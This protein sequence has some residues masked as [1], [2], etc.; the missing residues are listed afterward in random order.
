MSSM[1]MMFEAALIPG[2]IMIWPVWRI[3]RRTGL[4]PGWA[5]L[6][7]LP[8]FG[9]LAVTAMLAFTRWPAAERSASS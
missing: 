2:F 3:F 5:L 8:A 7:F 1:A 6:I 9:W 4:A